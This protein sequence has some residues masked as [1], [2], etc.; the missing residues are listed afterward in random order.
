MQ[1][2][3]I[4]ISG[5]VAQIR[6]NLIEDNFT[7]PSS[8]GGGGLYVDAGGSGAHI[9][10][11]GNR[12]LSNS[13]TNHGRRHAGPGLRGRSWQYDNGE[14]SFFRRRDRR[15]RDGHHRQQSDQREQSPDR[16]RH[17]DCQCHG[18]LLE[19]NR[20]ID[21]RATNGDGGGM[22]LWG[23]FFMDV[24]LDGNQVISNTASTKGGGI[25]L[26]CPTGVDPIDI[27]NTV[28]ADN[29]AATGSGLYL[30]VC[31]ANIAYS[32]VASNGAAWGDGIGFYLRDPIA[33]TAAYTI[34]NSIVVS[35][36]VGIYVQSG[37]ASLEAT[38][39]G[40]GDWAN[41]ADTGGSG[42]IDPGT[43]TYQGDPGFVNPDE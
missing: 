18:L 16:G 9:L 25:Y 30:T 4:D 6:N 10:V 14:H 17:Q 31:D 33:G 2:G 15:Y 5:S 37:S 28:L 22:S 20:V 7:T 21:N 32:T 34:E 8:N 1:G 3:G 26:E 11:S 23:G 19:R 43:L 12:V 35:Q 42:T 29:I 38:F 41:D 27:S 13:S 36:T 39:W 40:D 24:T